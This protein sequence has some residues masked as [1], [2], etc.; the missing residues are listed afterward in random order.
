VSGSANSERSLERRVGASAIWAGGSV[1]LMRFANIA[2]MAV[3]ARLVAPHDL[4]VF[5][6]AVTAYVV[7]VTFGEFGVSSALARS[8]LDPDR[9]AP[10]VT[11]IAL[12]T[13]FALSVLMGVFA[14]PLATAL[15]SA[16]AAGPLRVLSISVALMGLSAVPHAQLQR[17]LRQDR[18]FRSVAVGFV[19]GTIV[20]LVLAAGG[21]GALAF[22]WGRVV[23]QLVAGTLM[24]L[25]VGRRYLPG[26]DRAEF[27]PLMRFGAPLAAANLLS[28]LLLNVDYVIVGRSLSIA[29][30]GVY[31]LAFNVSAWPAAVL[32]TMLNSVVVPGFSRV[33]HDPERLRAALGRAARIVALIAF[34]IGALTSALALPLI[35]TLY[36]AKWHESASVLVVLTL[37]GVLFVLGLLFANIIIV[38]GRTGILLGVQLVVLVCLVPAMIVGIH[39]LGLVGVGVAHIVVI[40]L[41]TMPVYIVAVRQSTGFGPVHLAKAI[42]PVALAAIVTTLAARGGAMLVDPALLKLMVGGI[43]GGAVYALL[44][45]PLLVDLLPER[46][47]LSRALARPTARWARYGRPA[48]QHASR[49]S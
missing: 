35:V 18:V 47:A 23:E 22:A 3:V 16:D 28:Q 26:F 25:S 27:G 9:I 31:M 13:S 1:M 36:G 15:G 4:G 2:T 43:A 21:N 33:R 6:L 19:A 38:A 49:N 41:V 12:G 37:H 8:D 20:L 40:C 29:Q 11:T 34:P 24:I 14:E 39:A 7:I 44:T 10:T 30:V 5:A 42:W 17:D 32:G 45:V 48:L 46:S